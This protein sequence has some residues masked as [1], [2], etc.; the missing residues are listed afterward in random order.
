VVPRN[1]NRAG[2]RCDRFAGDWS[3][4]FNRFGREVGEERIAALAGDA[5]VL[6]SERTTDPFLGE[7]SRVYGIVE[8]PSP[9]VVPQVVIRIFRANADAGQC[10]EC[11]HDA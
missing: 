3:D 9:V 10:G 8:E 4:G 1:L 6:R 7:W 11:G 5:D 2:L